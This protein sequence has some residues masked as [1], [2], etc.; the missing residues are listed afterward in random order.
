MCGI[1]G[2]I[3]KNNNPVNQEKL[4]QMRDSLV[5][6][7]PDAAGIYI[8]N[9]IGLAHRRL[10]IIDRFIPIV[11]EILSFLT[12]KYLTIKNLKTT[13]LPTVISSTQNQIQKSYFISSWIT[14]WHA[15]QNSSGFGPS[16][17]TTT[18]KIQPS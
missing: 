5:H 2:I 3:N 1:A 7:G 10:S 15:S 11:N 18:K 14:A 17:S 12:G 6:R 8:H 13:L 4:I 9:N 16:H